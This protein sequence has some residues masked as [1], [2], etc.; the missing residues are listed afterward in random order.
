MNV[1]QE[2]AKGRPQSWSVI[3]EL[4][5]ENALSMD[6]I[7]ANSLELIAGSTDTV[8]IPWNMNPTQTPQSV[9]PKHSHSQFLPHLGHSMLLL[10]CGHL[11]RSQERDNLP[12][13][14]V[15]KAR[16]SKFQVQVRLDK[17]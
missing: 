13:Q 15:G 6:G 5:A 10:H 3:G 16:T 17:T 1:Y 9:P 11:L 2:L 8:R 12:R 4:V 7:Q 14:Y